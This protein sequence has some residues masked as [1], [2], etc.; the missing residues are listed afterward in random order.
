MPPTP[1]TPPIPAKPGET[2]ENKKKGFPH[3]KSDL[4]EQ[5]LELMQ[6]FSPDT[7]AK[8]AEGKKTWTNPGPTL[9]LINRERRG[10]DIYILPGEVFDLPRFALFNNKTVNDGSLNEPQRKDFMTLIEKFHEVY[11]RFSILMPPK[12]SDKQEFTFVNTLVFN[13]SY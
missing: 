6:Q 4:T 1:P 3:K 8:D 2:K 7:E 5:E 9:V 10:T 13:C 11:N 12:D